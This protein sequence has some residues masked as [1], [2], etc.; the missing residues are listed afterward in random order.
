MIFSFG[1]EPTRNQLGRVGLVPFATGLDRNW[2]ILHRNFHAAALQKCC[3][4][5]QFFDQ[6]YR[7]LIQND[8]V[9]NKVL[10]LWSDDDDNDDDV[11]FF[12]LP[13]EG[14][15]SKLM[16]NN[17]NFFENFL[18]KKK[19]IVVMCFDFIDF[20]DFDST[21]FMTNFM[22][23]FAYCT[24]WMNFWNQTNFFFVFYVFA[25]IAFFNDKT[26]IF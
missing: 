21:I 23:I 19:L 3:F 22:W 25:S 11:F 12:T 5:K 14:E 1:S 4:L 26:L 6:K 18:T 8:N 24:F 2:S 16:I 20:D 7:F 10:N 17:L 9:S 15:I 13:G